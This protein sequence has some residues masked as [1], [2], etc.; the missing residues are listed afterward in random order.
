MPFTE[1]AFLFYFLPVTLAAYHLAPARLR[2]LVLTLASFLFYAVGEW[3]FVGWLLGSTAMTYAVARGIDAWRGQRRALLLL[4]LGLAV[5]LGLLGYF[6]YA[7]FAVRTMVGLGLTRAT[8]PEILLPLGISFFTFHK[9]SYKV[10]VWRG[11]AEVRKDPLDLLLYILL[12]PAADRRADRPLPRHRRPARRRDGRALATS[13]PASGASSSGSPRRCWWRTRSARRRRPGVRRSPPPS[14]APAPPGSASSATRCRSTS[15][16]PA[17]RTWRSAWRGCSASTSR[18]T[19]DYPYVAASVTD[20]WR[21]W[22]ISLSRWF[23]DY[24]YIPLGAVSPLRTYLN[25]LAVELLLRGRR[26]RGHLVGGP[27]PRSQ[28]GVSINPGSIATTSI[29]QGRSSWRR[30]STTASI[31]NFAAW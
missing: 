1:P 21:R 3:A 31:P 5:D 26:A 2:N 7:G 30:Q 19:S 27:H 11:T 29:P 12:L 20:F 8:V 16:S 6:K 18:R 4:A 15:T 13:R 23:R 24:L 28:I 10:D 17:T 25:L 22:H 9:I 14:S